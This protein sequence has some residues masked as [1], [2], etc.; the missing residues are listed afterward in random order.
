MC[1]VFACNLEG[2]KDAWYLPTYQ[3]FSNLGEYLTLAIPS[4]VILFLDYFNWEIMMIMAGI[5][6]NANI[7]ASQVIIS[8]VGGLLL[9]IPYGLSIGAVAVIGTAL[10]ANKPELAKKNV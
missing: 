4:V 3:T 10:G 2:F 7:L 1:L 5:M 6:N 8:T 9:M